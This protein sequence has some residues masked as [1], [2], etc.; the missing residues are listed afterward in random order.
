MYEEQ[1]RCI[2]LISDNQ[3]DIRRIETQFMDTGCMDCRLNRCTT[4][5][6]AQELLKNKSKTIDIVILDMRLLDSSVSEDHYN[7][8]KS[9]AGD[10]PIIILTGNKEEESK[11]AGLLVSS[12]AAAHIHLNNFGSLVRTIQ[13]TLF[14][15][16]NDVD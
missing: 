9:S 11:N 14:P 5:T 8:I 10:I 4:I 15:R 7:L 3:I 6:A 13:A 2:L 1:H 16:R 12:G